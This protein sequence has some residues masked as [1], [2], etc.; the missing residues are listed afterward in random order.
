MYGRMQHGGTSSA[1]SV[2]NNETGPIDCAINISILRSMSGEITKDT[3]A[4]QSVEIDGSS[5]RPA[6]RNRRLR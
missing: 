4:R 5:K 3:L 1:T 2:K 6:R